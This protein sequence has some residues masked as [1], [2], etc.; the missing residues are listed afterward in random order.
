M[1]V[2]RARGRERN[3]H[4]HR[5]RHTMRINRH[6]FWEGCNFVL[7]RIRTGSA[8]PLR[9]PSTSPPF[10]SPVPS[11]SNR[12]REGTVFPLIAGSSDLTL[13]RIAIHT[14]ALSRQAEKLI[15][16]YYQG[17]SR[18]RWPR[19]SAGFEGTIMTALIATF[20]APQPRLMRVCRCKLLAISSLIGTLAWNLGSLRE[21][22][23]SWKFADR[24]F[25]SL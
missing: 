11:Y 20:I 21:N 23:R 9:L 12:P 19:S 4:A 24:R 22:L 13:G 25:K 10:P 6:E 16:D 5:I 18:H 1:T 7:N 2:R 3:A 14:C 17:C 15:C 8:H